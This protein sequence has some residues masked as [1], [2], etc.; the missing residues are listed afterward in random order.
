MIRSLAVIGILAVVIPLM[1]C[2]GSAGTETTPEARSFELPTYEDAA[3]AYNESIAYRDRVWARIVLQV[4]T[5]KE[6]GGLRRDQIEGYLQVARPNKV[7][8]QLHKLGETLF[9]FG[10]DDNRYWWFDLS[11]SDDKFAAV[12]RHKQAGPDT[13]GRLGIPVQPL[14][15]IALIGV[16]PLPEAGGTIRVSADGQRY[17]IEP[18]AEGEARTTILIDPETRAAIGAELRDAA[19]VLLASAEYQGSQEFFVE[20]AALGVAE[21]PRRYFIRVPGEEAEISIRLSD[22]KNQR[23]V[24]A[25]FDLEGLLRRFRIGRVIDLDEPR[26]ADAG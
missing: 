22:P 12:G 26:S 18:P 10:S 9:L 2:A 25:V 13:A 20:G 8:I 7:S 4:R 6:D 3:R 15:L 21:I 11:E 1:G 5:P 19:G 23:L 16:R 17:V 24:R 14:E